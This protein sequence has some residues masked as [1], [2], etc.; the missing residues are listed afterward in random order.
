[1]SNM[2]A[3]SQLQCRALSAYYSTDHPAARPPVDV[4]DLVHD[5]KPYITIKKSGETLAIYRVRN[6]GQLKRMSRCP[7]EVMDV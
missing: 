2:V 6:N 1:M 7:K 3:L 4:A 5:G